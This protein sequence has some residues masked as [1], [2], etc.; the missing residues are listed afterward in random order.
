MSE[1]LVYYKVN[2]EMINTLFGVDF[3]NR[4]LK[5]IRCS[6][7]EICREYGFVNSDRCTKFCPVVEKALDSIFSHGVIKP[8]F[9]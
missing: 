8:E 5:T 2:T 1:N 7:Y 4:G 6:N 9:F 3:E